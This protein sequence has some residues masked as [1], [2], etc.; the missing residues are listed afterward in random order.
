MPR[1]A[2]T[3]HPPRRHHRP[4]DPLLL[5]LGARHGGQPTGPHDPSANPE[6]ALAGDEPAMLRGSDGLT[7]VEREALAHRYDVPVRTTR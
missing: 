1:A 7:D 3:G 6:Q 4:P 2:E 5:G